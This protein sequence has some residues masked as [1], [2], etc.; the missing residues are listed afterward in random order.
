MLIA[1]CSS[2]DT[3]DIKVS[4]GSVE[5][6]EEGKGVYELQVRRSFLMRVFLLNSFIKVFED[7]EFLGSTWRLRV[8]HYSLV[9]VRRG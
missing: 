2:H 8:A 6:F 5:A 7:C 9:E 3:R 1:T 4:L